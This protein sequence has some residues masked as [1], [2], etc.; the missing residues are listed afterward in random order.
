ML[1][2]MLPAG[3]FPCSATEHGAAEASVVA[4]ELV[5][6]EREGPEDDNGDMLSLDCCSD[7][8]DEV[9]SDPESKANEPTVTAR[10]VLHTKVPF[11]RCAMEKCTDLLASREIRHGHIALWEIIAFHMDRAFCEGGTWWTVD[12]WAEARKSVELGLKGNIEVCPD[13]AGVDTELRCCNSVP[14]GMRGKT[15]FGDSR[16]VRYL[17]RCGMPRP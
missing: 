1:S 12:R 3:T 4:D 11:A 5:H 13:M 6:N 16:L 15:T 10:T 8:Q 2:M 17:S 9:E 14:R 7:V